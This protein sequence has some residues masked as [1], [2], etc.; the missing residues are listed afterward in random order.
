MVITDYE[1]GLE[2]N[3]I[4]IFKVIFQC[5]KSV[6]SFCYYSLKNISLGAQ[7]LLVKTSLKAFSHQRRAKPFNTLRSKA[8][9]FEKSLI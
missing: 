7:L 6:E 9:S 3:K 5:Q 1:Y 8:D 4:M 2:G